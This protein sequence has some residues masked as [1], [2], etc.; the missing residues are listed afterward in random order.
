MI[1]SLSGSSLFFLVF[2]NG[3]F[4]LRFGHWSIEIVHL[5]SAWGKVEVEV[6]RSDVGRSLPGVRC[7]SF[8]WALVDDE[9]RQDHVSRVFRLEGEIGYREVWDI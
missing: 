9:E 4:D 3:L 6:H 5:D 7:Q 1:K 8:L 2:G